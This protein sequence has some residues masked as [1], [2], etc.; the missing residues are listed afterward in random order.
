[1]RGKNSTCREVDPMVDKER[2]KRVV[3]A[4]TSGREKKSRIPL[5]VNHMG[6]INLLEGSAGGGKRTPGWPCSSMVISKTRRF[7]GRCKGKDSALHIETSGVCM[8]RRSGPPP[9]HSL[10][11]FIRRKSPGGNERT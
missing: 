10:T 6:R 3:F 1:M 5:W 4:L 11:H 2:L 9:D 7:Q 8:L